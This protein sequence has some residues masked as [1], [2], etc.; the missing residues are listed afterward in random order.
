MVG[1]GNRIIIVLILVQIGALYSGA[2]SFLNH[3]NTDLYREAL[4]WWVFLIG[5]K[6]LLMVN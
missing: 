5:G 1:R 4:F 6:G 2:Y 3:Y